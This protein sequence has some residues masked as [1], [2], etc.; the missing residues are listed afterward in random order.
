MKAETRV[1]ALAASAE[2]EFT[3][4]R[5]RP[6]PR[7]A[8]DARGIGNGATGASREER[9]PAPVEC[10]REEVRPDAGKEAWSRPRRRLGGPA[11]HAGGACIGLARRAG[12]CRKE[13]QL[14]R[15][16]RLGKEARSPAATLAQASRHGS[17]PRGLQGSAS[18]RQAGG[19]LR[20]GR[21]GDA[22]RE[23]CGTC[24]TCL[25]CPR[26]GRCPAKK[27]FVKLIFHLRLLRGTTAMDITAA[28]A[29]A[30][31]GT[32]P[33]R[34]QSR[35]T[36]TPRPP[37]MAPRAA[38]PVTTGSRAARA[39]PTT[40]MTRRPALLT[41]TAMDITTATAVPKNLKIHTRTRSSGGR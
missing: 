24:G 31:A 17:R 9:Q 5:P 29:A 21:A 15:V 8:Q 37:A 32:T 1:P 18:R 38:S 36:P 6:C 39:A 20:A 2:G 34:T 12:A 40:T 25:P 26:Q 33:R 7:E 22:L 30:T 23:V 10:I 28:T 19:G 35:C 4:E 13:Q 27:Q 41:T 3:F 11:V 16:E 14:V